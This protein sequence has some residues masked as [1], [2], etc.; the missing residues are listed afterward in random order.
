MVG[1]TLAIIVAVGAWFAM[2][3]HRTEFFLDQDPDHATVY[4]QARGNLSVEAHDQLVHS[5]EARLQNI[6]GVE[7]IYVRSGR[8][9]NA[10]PG[11]PPNDPIGRIALNF[12]HFKQLKA[13]KLTGNDIV[14]AIRKRVADVPGLGVEVRLPKGGPTP[15]KDV[16][17]QLLGYDVVALNK[18]T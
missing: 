17:I 16:Q 7:S 11:G 5:V 8:T 15:G 9:S 6:K 14:A 1:V 3:K 13:D 12:E 10:G 2:T 4:V 18:A